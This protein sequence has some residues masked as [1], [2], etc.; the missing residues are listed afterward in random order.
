MIMDFGIARSS[1]LK[2]ESSANPLAPA[3]ALDSLKA[4]VASTMVGTILGTVQYMAPEQAKALEVDQRA[5]IY[6][7]GL[8]LLDMLLGKR[9]TKAENAVE[10][11][12]ARMEHAPPLAQTIDPTIPKPVEQLIAKCLEPDRE[13]RYQTSAELVAALDRLDATG[14]LIPIRRVVRLPMRSRDSAARGDLIGVWWYQRQ[15]IPPVQHDRVGGDRRFP[16][17]H[18]G[19][20]L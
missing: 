8:I 6:A 7:L 15:F 13:Q 17:Q 2:A 5:D 11:L 10:E 4:S 19:S 18:Q 9:H 1:T 3:Q 20:D 12:K 14:E 16:E